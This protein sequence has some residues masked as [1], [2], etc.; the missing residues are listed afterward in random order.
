MSQKFVYLLLPIFF[1]GCGTSETKQT[2]VNAA[3]SST[4]TSEDTSSISELDTSPLRVGD[5]GG[6]ED[7]GAGDAGLSGDTGIEDWTPPVVAEP[8]P[9][10]LLPLGEWAVTFYNPNTSPAG[11]SVYAALETGD[12]VPPTEKGIHYEQ[13]W[14]LINPEE[15]GK[16]DN[17]GGG[18]LLYA[19]RTLEVEEDT[20]LSVRADRIYTVWVN[21]DRQPGDLYGTGSHRTPALLKAGSNQIVLR[22]FGGNSPP[23]LQLFTH[24]HEVTINALDYTLPDLV[25]GEDRGQPVGLPVLNHT[26]SSLVPLHLTVYENEWV[27]EWSGTFPGFAPKALSKIPFQL[28]PKTTWPEAGTAIEFTVHCA[29]PGLNFSYEHSFV[30]ETV[31]GDIPGPF[32]RT[33]IS[34]MDGSAQFYGEMRPTEVKPDTTYSLALS[35]HGASVDA[36]NQ[37]GSYSAKDWI[38]HVAATNRRPFGFDWQAWGRR[39]AIEV[40]NHAMDTYPIDPNRVYLTGHSMGG[41]GTWHLGTLFPHRFAVLGPS[42]GW[43]S[44]ETYGGSAPPTGAFGFNQLHFDPRSFKKNLIEKGVYIIHGTADDNVPIS[45][46]ETMYAELDGLVPELFFHKEEGAGHWWDG[47]NAVGVDC[48]DWTELFDLMS[49]STVDPAELNFHYTAPAP[50][51]N[52]EYSYVTIRSFDTHE[53]LGTLD[54]SY[55][56]GIL[57]LETTNIR[58]LEI[59]GTLLSSK[60]VESLTIDGTTVA[61]ES[62]TLTHGP[63]TGK[64]PDVYGP[65]NQI[66]HR[67]F[68]FVYEGEG[69]YSNYAAYLLSNWTIVGNGVGCALPLDALSEEI[70]AEYNIIYLG[71]Q[72]SD[73]G[74]PDSIAA[75]SGT[76]GLGI[77]SS[78]FSNAAM[79]F[80]FPQ[81]GRL[82]GAVLATPGAENLLFRIMPF[83]SRFVIPDY[84]IWGYGGGLDAG[85]F[86]PQWE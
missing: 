59:D 74:V 56:D 81:N 16:L 7:A 77:G 5:E 78:T 20:Y 62:G 15:D 47:D 67:P 60:G 10:E 25:S 48:V 82:A 8:S 33:F 34:E 13:Y 66:F 27:E 31:P 17:P 14:K 36:K 55:A 28:V 4:S 61:L 58:S 19:A 76:E 21:E 53:T 50:W 42:A 83:S 65:F 9:P 72:A 22:G 51:V 75:V 26:E 85:F 3:D 11:D 39:D 73:L 6:T 71:I 70:R 40:L 32:R 38:Y 12:F 64:S 44:F 69:I 80:I 68:C 30:L 43:I 57:A 49:L 41:H 79:A 84:Y 86:S 1:L 52:A 35:L 45:Q 2:P 24:A 46:A 54:S 37:A 18:A 29:A 23:T 63:Q